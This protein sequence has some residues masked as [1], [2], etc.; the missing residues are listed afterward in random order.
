MGFNSGFK[1]LNSSS[2]LYGELKYA[3]VRENILDVFGHCNELFTWSQQNEN[4]ASNCKEGVV[5]TFWHWSFTF[6]F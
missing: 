5:L 1:G 2:M 3:V 4:S 6:K